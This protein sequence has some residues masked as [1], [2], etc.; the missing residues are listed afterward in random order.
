MQLR[1]GTLP[2]AARYVV[3]HTLG[4]G[5]L[6]GQC[7]VLCLGGRGHSRAPERL[8]D[9]VRG[10]VR[11]NSCVPQLVPGHTRK[12]FALVRPSPPFANSVV[13]RAQPPPDCLLNPGTI[14]QRLCTKYCWKAHDDLL[15][16]RRGS[17]LY[18]SRCHPQHHKHFG[19][20][21][22]FEN[23]RVETNR[24]RTWTRNGDT[25]ASAAALNKNWPDISTVQNAVCEFES[26]QASQAVV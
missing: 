26:S 16:G 19:S 10:I 15:R 2:F 17:P 18:L 8:L 20:C 25:E 13:G 9:F 6:H 11:I 7:R 12:F 24:H 23:N 4:V 3:R 1:S 14:E 21:S 22:D 5:I